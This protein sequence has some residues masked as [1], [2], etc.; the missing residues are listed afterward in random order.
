MLWSLEEGSREKETQSEAH[1]QNDS[2]V[3]EVSCLATISQNQA[4][5]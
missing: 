1:I 2:S 5:D 4:D 3:L